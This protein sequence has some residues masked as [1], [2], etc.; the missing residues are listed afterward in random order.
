[1]TVLLEA[2]DSEMSPEAQAQSAERLKQQVKGRV[3]VSVQVRMLPP[4]GV[5]RSLG[6][7]RRVVDR[8]P[9]E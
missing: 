7:A 8:R 9:K 2:R 3:G 4:G 5:E 6:K 1:M